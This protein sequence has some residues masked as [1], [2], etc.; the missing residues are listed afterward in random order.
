[1]GSAQRTAAEHTADVAV[2]A[3]SYDPATTRTRANALAA[4][5]G[6]AQ[7]AT[8]PALKDGGDTFYV[9]DQTG[10]FRDATPP[11]PGHATL[12]RYSPLRSHTSTTLGTTT[13]SLTQSDNTV[14]LL[15]PADLQPEALA[16]LP[17]P[18]V[19]LRLDGPPSTQPADLSELNR[20][21]DNLGIPVTVT[22]RLTAR[23]ETE[24]SINRLLTMT[25]VL[26]LIAALIAAVGVS[27][28]VLLSVTSRARDFRLL[29]TIGM[30]STRQLAMILGEL[31]WLSIPAA[32][33]GATLGGMLGAWSASTLTGTTA[34]LSLSAASPTAGIIAVLLVMCC[35]GGAFLLRPRSA[36]V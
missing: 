27:N 8:P 9:T 15:S 36:R 33:L 26:S 12:G 5:P 20:T 23:A 18:T 16:A 3:L 21:L 10:V 19:F 11:T 14:S 4:T 17:Q 25:R 13:L 35:G 24:E 29:G 28:T 32:V 1:M 7:V 31:A 6:V 34:A 30:T 22:E 2:T